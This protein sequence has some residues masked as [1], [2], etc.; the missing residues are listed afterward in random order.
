MPTQAEKS[1]AFVHLHRPGNCFVIPNPW[2][3]GS[4]RLLQHLGFAALAS[5]GAGFAF[6]QGRTDLSINARD[7]LPYLAQLC[8]AS[9]LPVSADLQ[10]GFG[11]NPDEAAAAIVAAAASG[12]VGGSIEDASGD[13]A[14]P[15]Y[16]I[17][18][19]TARI[20]QA[21]EAAKSLG[22]K[23]MLTARAE[24]YLYDRPDVRDTIARLQA[25][26]DAG[27]DVLYAPGITSLADL[28]TILAEI[29]RPLNVLMGLQGVQLRV[30]ELATLGVTRISVGG[31]MARAAYGALL[32]AGQEIMAEGTFDYAVDAISGKEMNAIFAQ[33]KPD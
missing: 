24:N 25:Y 1:Q 6:S 11:P 26:Q 19:A 18:L 29:D 8:A 20:A 30:A 23:F 9:D 33:A 13:A 12:V 22:F 32:R 7:L 27:A 2:D 21:A 5:T 15:I 31:S 17:G 4:A 14:V 10:N 16:D 28:K 3:A